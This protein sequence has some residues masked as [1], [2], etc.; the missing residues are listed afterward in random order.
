[1][2]K[3]RK[4]PRRT[5]HVRAAHARTTHIRPLHVALTCNLKKSFDE[6]YAEW[7][8]EETIAAVE[9]ALS[10]NHKVT[11]VVANDPATAFRELDRLRPDIVFNMVEGL[12]GVN[13]E[14]HVPAMLEALGIPF[15]GSDP[16]T[17]STCLDKA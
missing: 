4:R 8:T 9:E 11:R 10:E 17:L 3:K 15:T 13:R 12:E 7:D 14:S 1:M 16:L 6:R 2:A 5:I